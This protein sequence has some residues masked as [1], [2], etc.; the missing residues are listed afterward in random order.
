MNRIYNVLFLC[1]GNSARSII[2]ECVLNRLGNGRFVAYSAGSRP[3]GIVHP[4]ALEL[5]QAHGWDTSAL[6]SKSWDEFARPD[7][8]KIDVVLTVC[9]NAAAEECP[10]WVGHPTTA[11]WGVSDPAA[12]I[13]DERRTRAA[14]AQT[15]Q[16]LTRRV[17]A[18]VELPLESLGSEGL[19][20]RLGEIGETGKAM[21]SRT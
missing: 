18:L 7:A 15:L 10:V 9:G 8:P 5:L 16:Q 19:R 11:H 20:K 1:T 13:G 21:E 6:R 17:R 2:A 14:F 3:N 12:V 4:Y